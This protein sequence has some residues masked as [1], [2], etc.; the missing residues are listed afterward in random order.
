M[1]FRGHVEDGQITLDDPA[2]LPE[3]AE[4]IVDVAANGK[5]ELVRQ[6]RSR[7]VRFDPDLARQIAVSA[8]FHPDE[9]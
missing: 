5:G 6:R 4:V 9:S 8:D 7:R 3:G 2:G 1:T